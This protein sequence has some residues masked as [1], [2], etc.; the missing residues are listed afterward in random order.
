MG[1][2]F[3]KARLLRR[4]THIGPP[5]H[6]TNPLRQ[7]MRVDSSSGIQNCDQ[8]PRASPLTTPSPAKILT[9]HLNRTKKAVYLILPDKIKKSRNSELIEGML[10]RT[11]SLSQ[12]IGGEGKGHGCPTFGVTHL[13]RQSVKPTNPTT[14]SERQK[15]HSLR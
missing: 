14:R 8:Q 1:I 13:N 7:G 6:L 3:Q 10:A 15:K 4:D 9:D 11:Q 12:E 2:H 5:N